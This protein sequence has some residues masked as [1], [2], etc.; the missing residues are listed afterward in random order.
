MYLT[1]EHLT[2]IVRDDVT[3]TYRIVFIYLKIFVR[4]NLITLTCVC[5]YGLAW[6]LYHYT[7]EIHFFVT[8]FVVK[9]ISTKNKL[10]LQELR[11]VLTEEKIMKAFTVLLFLTQFIAW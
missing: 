11:H 8:C 1:T 10:V 5:R 2:S 4:I 3:Y 9:L 7:P 6:C